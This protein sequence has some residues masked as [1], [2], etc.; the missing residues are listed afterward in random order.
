[1]KRAK[2]SEAKNGLSGPLS[3]ER[4]GVLVPP[5]TPLAVER[6]LDVHATRLTGGAVASEIIVDERRPRG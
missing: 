4:R 5:R 2:L 6:F 1:M 3:G